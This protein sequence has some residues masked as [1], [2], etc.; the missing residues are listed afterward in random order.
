MLTWLRSKLNWLLGP[1]APAHPNKVKLSRSSAG[2]RDLWAVEEPAFIIEDGDYLYLTVGV[3]GFDRRRLNDPGFEEAKK[4]AIR[5]L[6]AV[7]RGGV[8]VQAARYDA[9]AYRENYRNQP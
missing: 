5:A 1:A 4:R 8:R 2:H 7:F 3:I 6:D 9:N